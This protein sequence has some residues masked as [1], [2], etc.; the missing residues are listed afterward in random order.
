[1]GR[2]RISAVLAAALAV[3]GCGLPNYPTLNPPGTPSTLAS[4][5]NTVFT[6]L[7]TTQN[8]ELEFR[9]YELFYKFYTSS[10]AIETNLQNILWSDLISTYGY[11]PVC[12]QFDVFSATPPTNLHIT[13]PY[14]LI[15]VQPADRGTVFNITVTLPGFGTPPQPAVSVLYDGL[16][17]NSPYD[18]AQLLSIRRNV[19]SDPSSA[20][21]GQPK[22]FISLNASE[23]SS[24]PS[25]TPTDRDVQSIW[26]SLSGDYI[27][28][29]MYVL[30]YGVQD[31]TTD[32]YS[33]P[34]YL[35]YVPVNVNQ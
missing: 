9:G 28:L 21:S 13:K 12:S 15:N 7:S 30:S 6:I 33:T 5:T 14:P 10:F 29:A 24:Y 16:P 4:E 17:Y 27:Y 32:L 31:F 26:G 3:C 8:N 18:P 1:V 19:G 20:S 22:Y 23:I 34:V 35:G 2:V 25:Y 11:K